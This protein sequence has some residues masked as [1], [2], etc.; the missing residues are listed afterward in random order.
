MSKQVK[1]NKCN[2][3]TFMGGDFKLDNPRTVGQLKYQLQG[4]I[5]ELDG[6]G[7]EELS[8]CFFHN[9]ALRVT[10]TEGIVQ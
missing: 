5:T 10:L 2:V 8:E 3:E 1:F 7:N 9:D 4:I 6:W